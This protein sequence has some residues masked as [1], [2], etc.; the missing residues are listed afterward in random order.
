VTE[1]GPFLQSAL[2]LSARTTVTAGLRYDRVGFRVDDRLI[3]ATNPDDSGR[4]LMAALS[5]S[6]GLTVNPSDAV[7]VYANVGSSF[8]TP[9]TTELANRPDTAGGGGGG[10][11][12]TLKPQH[13]VN[14]EIGARS[15]LG[16]VR[17][18]SW[19]AALFRADVRDELISYEV[20]SSP[21]RRFFRNAG[22]SRHFGLELGA[23]LALLP[24]VRLEGNYT[25]SHF[26]YV[27]YRF[28]PDTA[29]TF[30]LDGRALP[31]VPPSWGHI[32]LRVSPPLARGGWAEVETTYSA[33]YFVDDTLSRRTS[34]W[35]A[36]NL[37]LGWDGTLGGGARVSPFLGISNLF[38]RLYVGSVVINAAG[39]R[40]YEP[41]PGRSFYIG[42]SVAAER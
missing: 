20:P 4:R 40:Y 25:F 2:D 39:G 8:E 18:L 33:P 29:R 42:V 19:T 17:R 10:F 3:T 13:A 16:G 32:L 6:L 7:T 36:S 27:H 9:T 21:Q 5:G 31:G 26:R 28:S 24:G 12:P 38:N 41:A 37:R 1:V 15:A 34:L 22:S 30:V 23:G 11:N 14:Y 35:W